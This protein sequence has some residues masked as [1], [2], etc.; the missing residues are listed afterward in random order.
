MAVVINYAHGSDQAAALA[1]KVTAA[2]GRVVAVKAD[3]A[4]PAAMSALFDAAETAFG[5]VDV[6]VN[7]AGVMTLTPIADAEDETFDRIIA[8]NQR[9]AWIG[10][11][12]SRSWTE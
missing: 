2:G 1:E 4:D 6:L 7:N 3:I 11:L 5:G 10:C 9:G 12:V 8:V